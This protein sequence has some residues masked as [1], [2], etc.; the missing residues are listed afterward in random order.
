MEFFRANRGTLIVVAIVLSAW[1]FL[2]TTATPLES[3]A[4]LD[5]LL[6]RGEPVVLQFFANT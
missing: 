3:V 1:L 4:S 2:R 5:D 6:Q